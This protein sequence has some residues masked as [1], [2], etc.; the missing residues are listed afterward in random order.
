MP[1]SDDPESGSTT[2]PMPS[3]VTEVV[4][5]EPT[6]ANPAA[7]PAAVDSALADE[8]DVDPAAAAEGGRGLHR[9]WHRITAGALWH[10]PDFL[11]LWVGDTAS[12][13]GSSF[14]GI[15]LPYLA[16]TVLAATSFQ[17]G[18]LGTLQGL[19]F[20]VI[21]LPAGALVDRWRKRTVMLGADLLRAALLLSLTVAWWLGALTFAQLAV[22]ATAVGVATVFFDVGYQSYLPFLVGREHVVEGNA[23]LQA[24]QSVSQA[25]GPAVGGV[26]IKFLGAADV[27]AINAAGYLASATALWR[28][29]H[30]ETP[31]SPESRRPLRT[32][33]AEGLRFVVRHPLLRRL[34]A[35]TGIGNLTGS[36]ANALIMLYMVR[37]LH[38]SAVAIGVIEAVG[39]IGGFAGAL[40]VTPLTRRIVDGATIIV[41]ATIFAPLPFVYPLASVLPAI[42]TLIV[43]QIAFM[44][45]VVAYNIATVSFRQR[46]CPPEMLGRMNASARF[47]IW[48]T[49]PIGA[50]VGGVLSTHIGV[51]ATL[52]VAAAAGLASI[53]PVASR[54]LWRL[55]KL[56]EHDAAEAG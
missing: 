27:V 21:G 50:F 38:L 18:L 31:P 54:S 11:R 20:L 40:I 47:L 42:P 9:L 14:G 51:L 3:S 5:T 13:L 23:K 35:C 46:L 22:A 32:E 33:I 15:A 36:A 1:D 30:R 12:Q 17:M 16:V 28:I 19:G 4:V 2:A 41:T 49:I 24:S 53:L 8:V 10:H 44:A 7:D 34:L 37:E 6:A 25:A 52:W 48:G 55:R 26:A 39:A 29:R 45:M 56:P 43:G